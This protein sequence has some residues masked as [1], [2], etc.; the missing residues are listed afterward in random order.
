[1]CDV[2]TLLISSHSAVHVMATADVVAVTDDKDTVSPVKETYPLIVNYC[3]GECY[4][5]GC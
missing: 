1:M 3:G 2:I 5:L 4:V